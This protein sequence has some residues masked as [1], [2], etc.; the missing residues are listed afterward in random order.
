MGKFFTSRVPTKDILF[1]QG[2][3][4]GILWVKVHFWFSILYIEYY[5]LFRFSELTQEFKHKLLLLDWKLTVL[6]FYLH[7]SFVLKYSDSFNQS[8]FFL[9]GSLVPRIC[10]IKSVEY[11][12][13]QKNLCNKSKL[14]SSILFSFFFTHLLL[15]YWLKSLWF[16]FAMRAVE[17]RAIGT[18]YPRLI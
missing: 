13:P 16:E 1:W 17:R 18:E 6:S 3:F 4:D 14:F 9:H 8:N 11:A 7:G 2:Y 12:W 15:V 5:F 10:P